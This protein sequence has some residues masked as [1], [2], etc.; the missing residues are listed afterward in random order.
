MTVFYNESADTLLIDGSP[1]AGSVLRL[2]VAAR[3]NKAEAALSP[4]EQQVAELIAQGVPQKEIAA[5]LVLSPK[6]VNTYLTNAKRSL[7]ISSTAELILWFQL[8]S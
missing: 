4:R 8:K 3:A 6:T 7:K 1:I 5:R 2:L